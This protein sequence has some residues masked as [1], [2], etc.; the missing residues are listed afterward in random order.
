M[1]T[2]HRLIS[3]AFVM[4]V[5]LALCGPSPSQAAKPGPQDYARP[6]DLLEAKLSPSGQRLALLMSL[7]EGR[8]RLAVLDLPL[9]DKPPRVV[10]SYS[11][12]DIE[13]FGWV[14]D[15]RLVYEVANRDEGMEIAENY[16]GTFAVDHDGKNSRQLIAWRLANDTTGT[17]VVSR[18][19]TYQWRWA[20]SIH[21]GSDDI[22]VKQP[23]FDA[24]RNWT[25]NVLARLNTVTGEL[26]RLSYGAPDHVTGWLTAGWGEPEIVSTR[27][28][29]RAKLFWRSAPEKDW[30]LVNDEDYI[31]GSPLRPRYLEGN[32]SLMVT[33]ERGGYTALYAFDLV[34]K[35]LSDGPLA[36]VKGFDL[37]PVLQID[38][39]AKRVVG[40][41]F[42][43]AQPGSYWFDDKLDRIQR[44]ID[45]SL[46][47]GRVNRISCGY[48]E[49]SRFLLVHSVSDTQ[50]G[51][52]YLFDRQQSQLDRLG[53]TRP[54]L[55]ESTQGKRS[56]HRVATRDGLEMPVYV[57]HPAGSSDSPLPAV[58]LV[59]G[60]PFMR[61]T[62]ATWHEEAQFLASRGYR[63]IEP[64]F[65][66]SEGY[67]Q[68]LYAAGVRQYGL[69]MQDDLQD[70][71]QWAVKQGL[72][73][74]KRVCI[75]GG[76]Y[77]GYAAL[78][79]PIRHPGDYRCAISFAGV[80]DLELKYTAWNSD[81]QDETR[82]YWLP[83]MIG[84]KD[85]DAEALRATSPARRAGEIKVPV[86]LLHGAQDR[87][88]PI[89]H[90][91]Q[92]VDAAEAAR[93]NVTYKVYTR[94]G[95]GFSRTE[96]KADYYER[97]EA[98]LDANIGPGAGKR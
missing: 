71:L 38:R 55:E 43:T 68:R 10:A 96:D 48:C 14:N 41:H 21:D 12:A 97:V 89:E 94:A 52:Y 82:K 86:L 91:R 22:W 23:Q 5:G 62:D 70:A 66:G 92:F 33:T 28:E 64:E 98:F 73:D 83:A 88:V 69:G 50:P 93:V 34:S 29:G 15:N 67:G 80:T 75:M 17:R 59:H 77:G 65:R 72:V 95:H 58:L 6:A 63:V 53:A 51:E 84:D 26:K 9:A 3:F 36:A 27:A 44:S 18:V 85:A 1:G 76:S 45:V 46:P 39:Q 61:G 7:P 81:L 11:N 13:E 16:A 8:N 32:N 47:K 79:G 24:R 20:R 74:E 42:R 37:D 31:R 19:L 57:T 49:S 90:A 35:K 54:W 30:L 4:G 78:M 25:N 2:W 60:G 87:R 56:Y 40:F